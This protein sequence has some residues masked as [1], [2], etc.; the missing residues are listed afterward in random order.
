MTRILRRTLVALAFAVPF[1]ASAQTTTEAPAG[2]RAFAV[3]MNLVGPSIGFGGIEPYDFAI[4]GRFERGFRALPTLGN[5]MLGL[6]VDLDF[7][8]YSESGA[9]SRI[10]GITPNV[11]YHLHIATQPKL[12]PYAG[13]GLGIFMVNVDVE[14]FGSASDTEFEP[15]F[16][17][18]ARYWFSPTLAGQAEFNSELASINLGAMFKF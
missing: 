16:K 5:G 13:I 10:I 6:G 18:G 12:D 2:D 11:S 7:L 1:A 14:G 4:G 15:V 17:A 3:G 9:S 8:N